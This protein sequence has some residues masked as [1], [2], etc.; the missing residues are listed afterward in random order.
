MIDTI[1]S[2]GQTGADRA[3]QRFALEHGYALGGWAPKGF[4]DENGRIP[5]EYAAHMR[6]FP[7]PGY[8]ARTRAN[9]ELADAT[10]IIV[11]NYGPLLG[12]SK[13]TETCASN[14][15]KPHLPVCLGVCWHPDHPA[16]AACV[17]EAA[18][19]VRVWLD[20]RSWPV[21]NVAGPRESSTPGIERAVYAVLAAAL[22]TKRSTTEARAR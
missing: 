19:T 8:P 10:L 9:V 12:G 17:A 15:R 13:L 5:E 1:I 20:A 7:K 4:V 18:R 21:L 22:P 14:A 2:G 16:F 6:E 11:P 3:A